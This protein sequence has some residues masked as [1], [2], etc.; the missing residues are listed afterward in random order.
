[1]PDASWTPDAAGFARLFATIDARDAD[2]FARFITEDGEF[3]FANAAPLVGR[4]AIREGVAGFF[5]AIGGCRHRLL[6]TWTGHGTAACEGEVTYT[7]RD[8]STLTVP[9]ANVFELDGG[10][11]RS[12][13]IYIDNTPLFSAPA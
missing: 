11:I 6:R 8:G 3:R 10:R 5:A 7:R 4:A 12:Y 1:M 2:A 13:R 9:F